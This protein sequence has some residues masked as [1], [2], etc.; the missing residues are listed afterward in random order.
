MAFN[1]IAPYEG[2]IKQA[3]PDVASD[4]YYGKRI[5]EWWSKYG[6]AEMGPD[7]LS[8][9]SAL[10]KPTPYQAPAPFQATKAVGRQRPGGFEFDPSKYLPAIRGTAESIYGPQRAQLE[11]LQALSTSK[12]QQARVTTKEDFAK[13]L[14]GEIEAINRRGAF[15]SGG[16]ITRGEEIGT[17]EQ[18]ALSDINLQ[19]QADSAQFLA[20]QGLLSAEQADYIQKQLYERESGAYGRWRDTVSDWKEDRMFAYDKYTGERAFDYN[21][22]RAEVGDYQ[23]DRA[24]V[25]GV[26]EDDRDFRVDRYEFRKQYKLSKAQFDFTKKKYKDEKDKYDEE[27]AAELATVRATHSKGGGDPADIS[28]NEDGDVFSSGGRARLTSPEASKAQQYP[29]SQ[30]SNKPT[31]E[32]EYQ[33]S[34]Y[35]F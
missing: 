10:N 5:G 25:R 15:F 23:A 35:G 19:Q 14:Q 4:P 22:Y 1:E 11:A 21:K 31:E 16:A 32:K 29:L 24:Y 18:R 3:R 12:A 30:P 8:G 20:Q 9:V 26:F 17:A 28:I 7:F 2:K 34:G 13:Q 33:S 6:Q 27:V